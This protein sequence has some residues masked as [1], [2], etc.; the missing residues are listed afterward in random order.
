[1][2][3]CASSWVGPCGRLQ[4]LAPVCAGFVCVCLCVCVCVCVCVCL[5]VSVCVCGS[6]RARV[7]THPSVPR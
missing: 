5:S 7:V 1:M 2:S 3:D 6:A 4:V